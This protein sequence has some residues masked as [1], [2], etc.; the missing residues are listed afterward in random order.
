VLS[1]EVAV[2]YG[3][4]TFSQA[5][6]AGFSA[7]AIRRQI[8]RGGWARLGRGRLEALDRDP[9]PGDDLV[10]AVLAFGPRAVA[11]HAS[12]A[13]AYGWDL[14]REPDCHHV[15]VPR[16][17]NC[18][19][20]PGVRLHRRDLGAEHLLNRGVLPLTSPPCTGLDLVGTLGRVETI[21]AL[22]SALRLGMLSSDRL[23]AELQA[24]RNWPSQPA[25]RRVV[26]EVDGRSG[27]VPESIARILLL[28][29]GFPVVPQHVVL[30]GG[31]FVGYVDLALVKA[32]VAIEIDGF[33]WHSS[34]E[35]FQRD[36]ERQNDLV[37]AGWTVLRFSA[38]DVV[39]RPGTVV[40]VVR[41]ALERSAVAPHTTPRRRGR[42]C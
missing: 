20:L 42:S 5:R 30:L 2:D 18:L 41:A 31:R 14:L 7:A 6:E 24:R 17:H 12:A 36:R 39:H 13:S 26:D 34:K 33:S 11:S 40:A 22:D 15:T 3:I 1:P 38:E 25:L 10:R 35:R 28:D 19:P 29:A 37:L 4:F 21:A 32:R 27:S 8:D 23:L 16:N 9:Q